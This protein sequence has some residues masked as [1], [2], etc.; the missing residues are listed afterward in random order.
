MTKFLSVIRFKKLVVVFAFIGITESVFTYTSA[1]PN[2][3]T[4]AP[5]NSNCTSCHIG[6]IITSGT[7]WNSIS[8]TRTGGGGLA[9]ALPNAANAMSLTFTSPT[10]VVMGFQLCV[11]PASAT[12]SSTSVGTFS[13][14]SS[15]LV[16]TS[17][18]TSPT[19]QYLMHTTAGTSFLSGTATWNFNWQTPSSYIGNP[20]F[21]VA[22]NEANGNSS[23][24]GDKIYIKTFTA[25]V[26]PVRWLDF[27][28]KQTGDGVQLKWSTA[29]EINNDKFEVERSTDGV[30]FEKIATVKGKGNSELTS[31]YSVIDNNLPQSQVIYRI[32]Q[33]D[34]DGKED[35]SK[36]I[37]FD[38]NQTIEPEIHV[39]S[40]EKTLWFSQSE[41]I[42]NI[43][44]YGL[45]GALIKTFSSIQNGLLP[46]ENLQDGLYI[47][48][49]NT[50]QGKQLLKKILLH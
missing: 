34:F 11:L 12:S 28:A 29:Q 19:R 38:P 22:I 2:G 32:K 9:G 10:E 7:I 5:G 16:Q 41:H 49:L 45:N 37:S 47:I 44:V 42:K 1:P 39:L 40:N 50:S 15:T 4:N 14:G 13:F 3:Y 17:S 46:L 24:S 35:F 48:E 21:Y 6:S 23:S 33:L 36:T 26:L 25:T 43:N 20:T 30:N 27:Y 31:Y 8:L 18:S